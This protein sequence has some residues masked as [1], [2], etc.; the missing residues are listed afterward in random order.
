MHGDQHHAL[1]TPHP[2]PGLPKVCQTSYINEGPVARLTR[3]APVSVLIGRE[4]LQ[5]PR[6]DCMV[7]GKAQL[8]VA[9]D[10][11]SMTLKQFIDQVGVVC[12]T[13]H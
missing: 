7:C 5:P 13:F 11:H 4:S 9:L 1:I 3:R 10:T 8:I 12:L 2:H 6:P